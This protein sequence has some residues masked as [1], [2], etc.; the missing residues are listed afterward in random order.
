LTSD[1]RVMGEHVNSPLLRLLG[2]A[3]A[4]IMAA[5]SVAMF[6]A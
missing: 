3:T 5:A 1:R 6:I 4:V 2:W